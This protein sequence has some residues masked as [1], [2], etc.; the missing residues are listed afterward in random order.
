MQQGKPIDSALD[1]IIDDIKSQ[2]SIA[3]SKMRKNMEPTSSGARFNQKQKE[4][5][6]KIV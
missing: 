3:K 4:D 5:L 6:N 1:L 2:A